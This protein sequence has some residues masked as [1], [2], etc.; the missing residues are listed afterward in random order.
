[1][2]RTTLGSRRFGQGIVIVPLNSRVLI[3]MLSSII[4]SISV[5]ALC[6]LCLSILRLGTCPLRRPQ[7]KLAAALL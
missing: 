1:M 4:D 2:T 5:F 7:A 6:L 3:F